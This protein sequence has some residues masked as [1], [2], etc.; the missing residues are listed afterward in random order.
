METPHGLSVEAFTRQSKLFEF[1]DDAGRQR[2][3]RI[4]TRQIYAAGQTVVTE[5]DPGDSFFVIAKGSVN[6][7]VDDFRR[8][9][10]VATLGQGSFFGEIA[11][12]TDQ[13]RSATVTAADA[14]ELLRFDKAPVQEILREYPRIRELLAKMGVRRSEDTLEKMMNDDP[15]TTVEVGA[16]PQDPPPVDDE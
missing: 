1:L 2:M 4:A 9:K 5:G 7:S 15:E 6:V 13:P 11:V 3:M 14:L 16:K 12:I 8:Q 10:R